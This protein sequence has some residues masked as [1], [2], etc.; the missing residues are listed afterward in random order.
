MMGRNW[1][2]WSTDCCWLRLTSGLQ[3]SWTSLKNGWCCSGYYYYHRTG[4]TP[5]LSRS[6]RC[7][8]GFQSWLSGW[9]RRLWS[10]SG[11]TSAASTGLSFDWAESRCRNWGS[12]ACSRSLRSVLRHGQDLRVSN[13]VLQIFLGGILCSQS[14]WLRYCLKHFQKQYSTSNHH[15][16]WFL[17]TT[18]RYQSLFSTKNDAISIT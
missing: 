5:L 11:C 10:R 18:F 17:N 13:V 3:G 7:P 4:P 2:V 15:Y 1:M 8:T 6:R 16:L 14:G 9:S 12:G